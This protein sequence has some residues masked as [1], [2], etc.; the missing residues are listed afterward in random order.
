MQALGDIPH[1]IELAAE[2]VELP[3]HET[4]T[5]SRGSR[6]TTALA[7]LRL[8]A[9]GVTGIGE[10][11]PMYYH[12]ESAPGIVAWLD[13][14]AAAVIG[15]DPYDYEG[16]SR[17]FWALGGP[18]SALMAIDGAL[19]DWVGRRH[20]IAVHRMLGVADRGVA[21]T[22]TISIDSLDGT[23]DRTRRAAGYARLKIKVGGPGDLERLDAIRQI[24]DVPLV[25]DGNEG[26]DLEAARELMPALRA[27]GVVVVEQ[28]LPRADLDGYRALHAL[29]D[30]VPVYWD[31]SCQ[32]LADVPRA[33][34]LAD[35]VN[36]KLA[37]CGGVRAG[38]ALVAAARAHGLGTMVGGMVESEIGI[39]AANVLAPL[40]D[41]V[42]LDGHLLVDGS[43]MTGLG[44]S[45]GA[46]VSSPGPGF[47][48]RRADG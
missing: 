27:R 21:T 28:P 38:L 11:A 26:W 22:Y 4:F 30:R 48:L 39:A 47:G 46:V 5:I 14:H 36:I 25:V 23:R 18:P 33:V 9:G 29:A 7:H 31:E 12:G 45:D 10:A 40:V 6:T 17:R 2:A 32:V 44:F 13:E 15:S 16:I 20:G 24:T 37:K 3:L 8:T 42:D 41:H 43:P 35:G 19:L 1:P 34:G